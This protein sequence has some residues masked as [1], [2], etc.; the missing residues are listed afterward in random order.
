MVGSGDYVIVGKPFDRDWM[1]W[2]GGLDKWGPFGHE[3]R[4]LSR[5][6]RIVP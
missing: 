3:A 6:C 4:F 1:V 5:E 2:G